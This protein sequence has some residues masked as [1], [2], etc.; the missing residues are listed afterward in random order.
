MIT[1][2]C[3]Y[4]AVI[5]APFK[6]CSNKHQLIAYNAIMQQ[7]KDRSMLV[8]HHILDNEASV[9]YKRIIKNEWGVEYQLVPPHIHRRNASAFAIRIS[10]ALGWNSAYF[11]KDLVGFTYPPNIF[12]T[13]YTPTSHKYICLGILPGTF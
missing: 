3:D 12:N 7:L 4:N 11:P 9:E 1:Y 2:H 5:A 8:D 10:K 6:S 13:Q